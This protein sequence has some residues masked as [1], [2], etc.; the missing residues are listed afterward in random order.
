MLG[1]FQKDPC[2][3][4]M[5]IISSYHVYRIISADLDGQTLELVKK[6][7]DKLKTN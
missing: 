3:H 4:S 2:T 6:E 5:F 7:K 1:I